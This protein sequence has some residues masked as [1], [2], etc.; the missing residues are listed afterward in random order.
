MRMFAGA[1]SSFQRLAWERN[2]AVLHVQEKILKG[3][4]HLNDYMAS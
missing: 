1:I 3:L 4:L 2:I